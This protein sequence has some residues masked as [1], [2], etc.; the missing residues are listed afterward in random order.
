MVQ[1]I[2]DDVFITDYQKLV[3]GAKPCP[4]CGNKYIK[5]ETK[6]RYTEEKVSGS[7][8]E[9]QACGLELWH[10]KH[11]P[12]GKLAKYETVMDELLNK[13]NARAEV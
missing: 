1:F 8:F 7:C 5:T 10:F 2:T 13:W 9:C 4:F 11:L 6:E 12:E 3:E